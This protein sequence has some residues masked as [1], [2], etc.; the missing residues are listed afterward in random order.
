MG[1]L[2]LPCYEYACRVDI[3]A[4]IDKQYVP[5]LAYFTGSGEEN[6]RLRRIALQQ[7]MKLNEYGLTHIQTGEPIP[8]ASE[9]QL[10]DALG[11]EYVLPTMR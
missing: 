8:L 7:N 9:E 5:A 3:R 2:R 10:Y 6:V 1:F 11:E 4:V